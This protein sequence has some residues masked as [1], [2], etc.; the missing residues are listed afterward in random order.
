MTLAQTLRTQSQEAR[1]EQ[2]QKERREKFDSLPIN[3]AGDLFPSVVEEIKEKFGAGVESV[4]REVVQYDIN[5]KEPEDDIIV[6]RI[7]ARR[8]RHLPYGF[9]VDYTARIEGDGDSPVRV[10]RWKI[11]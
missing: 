4:T 1:K 10:H 3:R 9:R 5:V 7:I 6:E 2:A 8:L 11:T